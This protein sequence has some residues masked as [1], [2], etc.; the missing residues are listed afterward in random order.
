MPKYCCFMVTIDIWR[1]KKL[2]GE[3]VVL[4]VGKLLAFQFDRV[5]TCKL[6][7]TPAEGFIFQRRSWSWQWQII[8]PNSYIHGPDNS[9]SFPQTL[10]DVHGPDNGRS[11]SQ[12]MC[13]YTSW[14]HIK[15]EKT[16]NKKH[17]SKPITNRNLSHRKWIQHTLS[18]NMQSPRSR[19]TMCPESSRTFSISLQARKGRAMASIPDTWNRSTR[20]LHSAS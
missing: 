11:F 4:T 3:L 14:Q 8:S 16:K 6:S 5:K 20:L 19:I 9:R 17:Q 7:K 15:E 2:S 10:T 18:T 13:I 12:T 1:C